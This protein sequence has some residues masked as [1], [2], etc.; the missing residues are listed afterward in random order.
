MQKVSLPTVVASVAAAF[1]SG[2]AYQFAMTHNGELYA[3]VSGWSGIAL[4]FVGLAG[5]LFFG[6]RAERKR[7]EATARG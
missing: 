3:N 6:L 4:A 1:G 2:L 7:N 5:I